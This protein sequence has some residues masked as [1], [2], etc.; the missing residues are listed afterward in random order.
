MTVQCNMTSILEQNNK[1]QFLWSKCVLVAS[2]FLFEK[3]ES[4]LLILKNAAR[5]NSL[6]NPVLTQ[7]HEHYS[8]LTITQSE[9]NTITMHSSKF[10]Y[11]GSIKNYVM[12]ITNKNDITKIIFKLKKDSLWNPQGKILIIIY[13]YIQQTSDISRDLW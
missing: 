5:K 11:F 2:N 13:N 6:D 10:N 7:L 1:L 4:I 3:Q 8:L 9:Q 12:E